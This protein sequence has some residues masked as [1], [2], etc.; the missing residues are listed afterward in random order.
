MLCFLL[1]TVKFYVVRNLIPNV[2]YN[3]IST[4]K[5]NFQK[6]IIALFSFVFIFQVTVMSAM[7]EEIV[8][9]VRLDK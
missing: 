8:V 5:K 6:F 7:G 1:S 9:N 2:S 3:M 4:K